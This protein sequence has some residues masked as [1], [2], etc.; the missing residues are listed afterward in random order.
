MSNYSFSQTN[1][2]ASYFGFNIAPVFMTQVDFVFEKAINPYITGQLSGGFVV[3]APYG[4]L[5]KIGTTKSLSK[6]QGGFLRIGVKGHLKDKF[7]SPFIGGLIINILSIEEGFS[8]CPD[9]II[10]FQSV[11]NFSNT[12][13]NLGVSG[14]VGLTIKPLKRFK[15]DFGV[16]IGVL[17]IDRLSDY[18]SFTP[19]MGINWNPMKTQFITEIKYKLKK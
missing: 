11:P 10:C 16:Q 3:N 1:D 6:R 13:Y 14:I 12:S 15:I 7:I 19:G 9:T 5:H 2:S 17:L 18:H 8:E 4:S